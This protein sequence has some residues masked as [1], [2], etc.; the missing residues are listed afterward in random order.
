MMWLGSREVVAAECQWQE[1][2]LP[3]LFRIWLVCELCDPV[4]KRQVQ[5][6]LLKLR[7]GS[8]V[9]AERVMEIGS[10]VK[11]EVA[12]EL[13]TL[14]QIFEM[15]EDGSRVLSPSGEREVRELQDAVMEGMKKLIMEEDWYGVAEVDDA[16]AYYDEPDDGE[17]MIK[18]L[19]IAIE[20]E[21]ELPICTGGLGSFVFAE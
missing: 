1:T 10:N 19:V 15:A 21:V 8:K 5:I 20:K 9:E 11:N 13:N 14:G 12:A 7:C 16:L 18:E 6:L 2:T 3:M 17:R 4:G